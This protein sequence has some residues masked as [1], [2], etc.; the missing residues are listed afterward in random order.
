MSGP[1]CLPVRPISLCAPFLI[2]SA[3]PNASDQCVI[4]RSIITYCMW[5]S[6]EMS[7]FPLISLEK[8]QLKVIWAEARGEAV[9]FGLGGVERCR[10]LSGLLTWMNC[11]SNVEAGNSWIVYINMINLALIN[12]RSVIYYCFFTLGSNH[13]TLEDIL[14]ECTLPCFVHSKSWVL[15]VL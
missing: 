4:H 12:H 10:G 7:P 11:W 9:W 14:V 2:P 8:S 1:I 3:L 6:W 13:E 15:C 5:M